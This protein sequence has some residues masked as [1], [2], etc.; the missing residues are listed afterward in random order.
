MRLLEQ[1][2]PGI[3]ARFGSEA[4]LVKISSIRRRR[5]RVI[6]V[7]AGE[8]EHPRYYGTFPRVLGR[9][10][11]EQN[12][13]T[14]GRRRSKMTGLPAATIGLVDRGLV[15]AGM[16][17]DVVTSSIRPRHRSCNVRGADAA[18]GGRPVSAGERP[19]GASG[20]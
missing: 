18:V 2:N 7:G 1:G 19:G 17:A 12:A 14:L 20:W 3:I 4:D 15:A 5:S 11:R 16:L 8:A 6:A 10:A 9:Y 13:L